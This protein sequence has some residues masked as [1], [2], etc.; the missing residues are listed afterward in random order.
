MIDNEKSLKIQN[1][2]RQP[3][4]SN[5]PVL[6]NKIF[7]QGKHQYDLIECPEFGWFK[8]S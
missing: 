8:E 4:H 7:S 6:D 3:K 5:P 1:P 2:V